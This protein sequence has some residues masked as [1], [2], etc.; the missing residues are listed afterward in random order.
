MSATS[1]V[2]PV[3]AA[4][5]PFQFRLW[6]LLV[7]MAVVCVALAVLVPVY[8]KWQ[9]VG[10]RVA[11]ENNLKQIGLALHNYHDTFKRFPPAYECDASGRPVHSWRVLI[12]FF[13]E[14]RNPMAVY[15]FTQPWDSPKN[16]SLETTFSIAFDS[17][18]DRRSGK[19][20]TNYVAIVGPGTMWSG[21]E[22]HRIADLKDG[23]SNTIMVVEISNSDI[24]W[25]E[26]RDLPIEDLEAWLDPQHKPR[27][28]G[29]IQGGLVA[30]ADGSVHYLPREVTIKELRALLTPAG[31]D[32]KDMPS[33]KY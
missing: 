31:N 7:A 17:P 21:P 24:H 8:R 10:R 3:V 11:S 5:R 32:A 18:L 2:E 12:S 25:M 29:E 14:S 20:M 4:R 26:P 28:G 22:S 16:R 9:R 6:H 19:C 15:D 13:L 23:T 1:Q 33:D 27:L 30:Y